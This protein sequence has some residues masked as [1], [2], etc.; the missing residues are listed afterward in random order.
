MRISR[1]NVLICPHCHEEQDGNVEDFVVTGRVGHDSLSEDR[2]I[3]C[4]EWFEVEF[5]GGTEYEVL[6]R[7]NDDD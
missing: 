1:G 5:I 3:E 4:D 7:E 2:C 6:E